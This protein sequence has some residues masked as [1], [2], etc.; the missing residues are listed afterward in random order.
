MILRNTVFGAIVAIVL[1]LVVFFIGRAGGVDFS[2]L[3]P[4]ATE[5]IQVSP[6]LVVFATIFG[7]VLSL[8][9]FYALSAVMED[10]RLVWI[11]VCLVIGA[12]S[13]IAPVNAAQNVGTAVLLSLMHVVAAGAYAYYLGLYE[14]A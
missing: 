3:Q 14:P 6:V 2:V 4:G 8:I 12:L 7:G 10:P 5:V 11:I 1:N 9:G 13:N